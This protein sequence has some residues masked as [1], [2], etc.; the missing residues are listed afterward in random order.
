[1]RG[2]GSQPVDLTRNLAQDGEPSWSPDGARIA[3]V[4]TRSGNAQL[5]VMKAD[6]SAQHRVTHDATS[7]M[8]P[9]WSPDG[10]RLAYMCTSPSPT[11]VTEICVVGVDG[12][13][14]RRL[15]SG[16]DNLYPHWTPGGRVV[17]TPPH[18]RVAETA[19][20]AQGIRAELRNEGGP[21]VLYAGGRLLAHGV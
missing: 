5:Y 8:A 17:W 6:G 14:R 15:S 11:I 3:F 16:G 20:S 19:Y 2:D 18:P 4:S 1:M 13:G 9:V 12:S 10:R 21:F 7:D